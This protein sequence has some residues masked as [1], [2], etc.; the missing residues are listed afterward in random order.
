[1]VG[2]Y[3]GEQLQLWA[4]LL[5][6]GG[7]PPPP[8]RVP[9]PSLAVDHRHLRQHLRPLKL[10]PWI[11]NKYISISAFRYKQ[12]V[13][14][15]KLTEP[16][17]RTQPY[18]RT[19]PLPTLAPASTTLLLPILR[20]ATRAPAPTRFPL[21]R[22]ITASSGPSFR[23]SALSS[24]MLLSPM[25]MGPDL[26][27]R[28]PELGHVTGSRAAIG[29]LATILASGC[30]TVP[31]PMETSPSDSHTFT[32]LLHGSVLYLSSLYKTC[33]RRFKV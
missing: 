4:E 27:N 22:I 8:H 17:V 16:A 14:D 9:A 2:Q 32:I 7:P 13:K 15:L 19:V 31:G 3:L 25:T 1:M 26:A 12:T 10:D 11:N 28:R 18:E 5:H 30:T 20:L 29:H 33:G 21:P 23:I 24:T 6:A